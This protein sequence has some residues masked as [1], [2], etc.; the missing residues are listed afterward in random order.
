MPQNP[1]QTS[2]S[3]SNSIPKQFEPKQN[4]NCW[5]TLNQIN[6]A[7]VEALSVCADLEKMKM[8]EHPRLIL[9]NFLSPEIC[10][11]SSLYHIIYLHI[12]IWSFGQDKIINIPFLLFS[13]FLNI[14]TAVHTQKLLHS[15][16]QTQCLLHHALSSYCHQ[17]CPSHHA[18]RAHPRFLSI[19]FFHTT[20]ISIL[21]TLIKFR[22]RWVNCLIRRDV[23]GE[24][25]GIFWMWVWIVCG[26]HRTR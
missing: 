23:E 17:L 20:R 25:G 15:W 11:V 9:P 7:D 6:G 8:E 10:K 16:V 4:K 13:F 26:V 12:C 14:G 18:L 3:L 2:F 19:F 22:C 1:N 24:S 5:T 21:L